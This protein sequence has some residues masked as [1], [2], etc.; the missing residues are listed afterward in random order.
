MRPFPRPAVPAALLAAMM[1]WGAGA[2]ARAPANVLPDR[3]RA[4]GLRIP[5]PA[6]LADAT[7]RIGTATAGAGTD[8]P[9]T[10]PGP[11][12][13][14]GALDRRLL[15]DR[16]ARIADPGFRG[17]IA[18]AP[19]GDGEIALERRDVVTEAGTLP[20]VLNR[21]GGDHVYDGEI[22][23]PPEAILQPGTVGGF[24]AGRRGA[25]GRGTLWDD[26]L[27]PFEVADDFC[28][29]AALA[30]AIATCEANT[31]FRFVARDGHRSYLR[32]INA[33]PFTSSRAMLGKQE[34][35]NAVRIQGWFMDGRRLP[36]AS[37]ADTVAHE[38]GTS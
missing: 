25:F 27:L 12:L 21:M 11:A 3:S 7:A 36:D 28:C 15:A 20:L 37:L 2:Q 1:A 19:A 34:G 17:I 35:E 32:F 8:R 29:R 6:G 30:T 31:G 13:P 26:A 22:V 38:I 4:A 10:P 33:E 5:L 16:A 24:A 9:V 14:P 23:V 18:V